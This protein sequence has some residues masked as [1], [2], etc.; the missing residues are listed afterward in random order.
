MTTMEKNK[1]TG[2]V[3]LLNPRLSGDLR[4]GKYKDVG[5]YLPPYGLLSIAA[6]LEDQGHRVRVLDADSRKGLSLTDIANEI[7]WFSPDLIGMSAYS[8]GRNKVIETADHLKTLTSAPI[9]VGGPHVMTFPEDFNDVPS[10]DVTAY[11]EGEYIMAELVS[12]FLGQGPELSGI[13]GIIYNN[14]EGAEKTPPRPL[15]ENLDALPYPAF[16]LLDERDDYRPMQLLYKRLPVMTMISGRGCPFNCIFCNSIWGKKVRLNSAEYIY[17]FVK[18]AIQ[19][20]GVKE[21]MFYEDSFCINKDRIETLCDMM[22]AESLDITWSCSVNVRTLTP[23]ILQKMRQAGC[24]LIS[25]GIESGNNE[26]LK[27][28]RKPVR[29]HEVERA[30]RMADKAGISMRGF[31]ML[32]HPVDTQ[33]TIRETIDFAKSLPLLTINFCILQLLPGSKV[34]EIAHDYGEV[35]YDLSL[36]TGHPGETMSFVPKGLTGDYLKEMQRKGYTEFF[37][38][39]VQIWRLLR[40]IGSFEDIRK[41]AVL[42]LAFIRLYR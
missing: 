42:F 9:V 20:F 38:R 35:N 14:G 12:H 7:S 2:R 26:V 8:I 22:I 31:F 17:G 5:S 39:P 6:V 29:R 3:L 41:Y 24:W 25:M 19:D 1:K 10:I 34:R 28:I 33:K 32:G 30:T 37:L 4:Y 36:G 40:S 11:G 15:I 27:F 18:K 23:P 21:I 16:H 13:T